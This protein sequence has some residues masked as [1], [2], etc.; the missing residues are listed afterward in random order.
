ME[1]KKRSMKKKIHKLI[2]WTGSSGYYYPQAQN[3][4][5]VKIRLL[6]NNYW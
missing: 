4:Y 6:Q 2:T 1:L 3:K 5:I